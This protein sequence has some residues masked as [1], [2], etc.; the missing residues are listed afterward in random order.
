[1]KLYLVRHGIT[2]WNAR[3]KIQGQVDIPLNEEESAWRGRRQRGFLTCR[4]TFVFQALYAGRRRRRGLSCGI[5]K[6]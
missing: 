5:G 3:K 4:L 1:M 2:D 6:H